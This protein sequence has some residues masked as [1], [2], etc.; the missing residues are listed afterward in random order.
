VPG[1]GQQCS[2]FPKNIFHPKIGNFLDFF[3]RVNF[4]NSAKF[5]GQNQKI[6]HITKL[7]KKKKKKK[8]L[9][10]RSGEDL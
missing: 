5:L 4:T 3:W 6:F 1:S 2:F 9:V 10:A 7:E 8:P